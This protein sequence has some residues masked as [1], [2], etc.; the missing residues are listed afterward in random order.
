MDISNGCYD[1]LCFRVL[2][3]VINLLKDD[4]WTSTERWMLET[5]RDSKR[6]PPEWV[7]DACEASEKIREAVTAEKPGK[8][9]A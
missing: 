8:T 9:A 2:K 5:L 4:K 6:E 3:K 7:A 1:A